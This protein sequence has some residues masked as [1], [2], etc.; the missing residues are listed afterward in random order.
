MAGTAAMR[1]RMLQRK[2][3]GINIIVIK[4]TKERAMLDPISVSMKMQQ[5]AFIGAC[6]ATGIAA[7][8]LARLLKGE[9]RMMFLPTH[10][11]AEEKHVPVTVVAAG[12]SWNDHYGK[13]AHDV[14]VEHM[15]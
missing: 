6:C 2:I 15:R 3:I 7:A 10:R 5:A 11:R 9:E 4:E 8:S 1:G 14:D 12:P 13:R